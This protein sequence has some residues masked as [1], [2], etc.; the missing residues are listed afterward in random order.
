MIDLDLTHIIRRHRLQAGRH[1]IMLSPCLLTALTQQRD[2]GA[3]LIEVRRLRTEN[4]RL[5][6]DVDGLDQDLCCC[7]ADTDR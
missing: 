3:L 2:I 6:D 4:E 1:K 5:R 7:L